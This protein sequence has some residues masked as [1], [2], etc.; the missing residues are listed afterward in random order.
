MSVEKKT[1][2]SDIPG[3]H[4]FLN[5]NIGYVGSPADEARRLVVSRDIFLQGQIG[6]CDYL[7]VEGT[8]QAD[9]FTARRLDILESGVFSGIAT[10]HDCVIAGRFEGTI[11]VHGRLTVK[12]T[13][14][15]RG[16]IAYGA[17]E[18]ETG[19]KIEGQMAFL[20]PLVEDGAVNNNTIEKLGTAASMDEKKTFTKRMTG[21]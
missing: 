12:S 17:M 1:I 14:Q 10:V 3:S 6:A 4:V 9:A 16:E 2:R 18:A 19:A 20:L 8:V 11:T 5:A 7:V 15:I 21:Y 13:G